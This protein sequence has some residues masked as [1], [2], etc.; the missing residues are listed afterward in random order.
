M[1]KLDIKHLKEHIDNDKD[2]INIRKSR[3]YLGKQRTGYGY[4]TFFICPE[5]GERRVK[6][7]S[8]D[9]KLINLSCRSCRGNNIYKHRTNIYDEGGIELIEYKF[10]KLLNNI[11]YK[12]ALTNKHIP[13]DYRFYW[14][15]R[16]KYMRY[17][18]FNHILKQLTVLS[19]MR[20]VVILQKHS[21]KT[22]DINYILD[23][24]EKLELIEIFDSIWFHKIYK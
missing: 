3:I 13:F 15:C 1:F 17:K 24:I 14:N 12:K 11:D 6:L 16:P 7:Y 2:Y 23:N 19:A 5:C 8:D 18:K 21:Y 4:K 20:D 22:K 9:S 10:Y